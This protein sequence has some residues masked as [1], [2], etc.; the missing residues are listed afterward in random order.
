MDKQVRAAGVLIIESQ[1]NK[2][3][4][5]KRSKTSPE[6][7]TWCGVGGKVEDEDT[8][9]KSTA[10]REMKEEIGYEG[11]I[12]TKEICPYVNPKLEFH[13]FIGIVPKEFIPTLDKSEN[14]EYK[15][16]NTDELITLENKHYGLDHIIKCLKNKNK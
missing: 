5:V 16:V 6:P 1:N 3:L 9:W 10:L 12:I 15:W 8:S 4:L 11:P 2:I 14:T 7:E 13:N